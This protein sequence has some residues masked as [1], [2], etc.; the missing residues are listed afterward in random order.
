MN[1]HRHVYVYVFVYVCV[2]VKEKE[3][4]RE[5]GREGEWDGHSVERGTVSHTW[6]RGWNPPTK[7]SDS[8]C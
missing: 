5:R 6:V 3:R 8:T 2:R 7:P 4:G 1:L